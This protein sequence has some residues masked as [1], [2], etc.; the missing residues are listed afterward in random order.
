MTPEPFPRIAHLVQGAMDDD[1]L[2]VDRAL[3]DTFFGTPVIVEEK[4]DGSNVM[5]FRTDYGYFDVAGRAGVGAQD[6][7]G[8]LG[9]LRAWVANN[10]QRL[11]A[12]LGPS[13]VLYA[14]WLWLEHSLRY[15]RLP[16]HLVVLDLWTPESGFLRVADRDQRAQAW[17]F[18]TA[19]VLAHGHVL[20]GPEDLDALAGTSAFTDARMEGLI[21][22]VEDELGLRERAKWVR[23]DFQRK[24]DS[25]WRS[26]YPRNRLIGEQQR[27]E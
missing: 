11:D 5:I 19:P 14:E 17:G 3:R 21:L 10:H 12:L 15:D 22:R 7:A 4:V 24:P 18:Y 2:L 13:E 27:D 9:P 1:D 23:P 20:R 6:R 16:D 26:P 8:Q 25:E